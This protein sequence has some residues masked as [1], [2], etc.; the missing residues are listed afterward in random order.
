MAEEIRLK[1]GGEVPARVPKKKHYWWRYLLC[2]IAGTLFP[3]V[4]IG[5]AVAI[6]GTV[7]KTKDLMSMLGISAEEYLTEDY[8]NTTIL[9]MVRALSQKKFETLED[10]YEVTP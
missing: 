10:I 4:L 8:Q 7:V 1:N 6:G 5:S 2:F 3:G 9:E